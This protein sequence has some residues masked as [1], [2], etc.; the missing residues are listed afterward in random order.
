MRE[1]QVSLIGKPKQ[2]VRNFGS[3]CIYDLANKI[4]SEKAAKPARLNKARID[5]LSDIFASI[6]MAAILGGVHATFGLCG[7]R[8]SRFPPRFVSIADRR[9]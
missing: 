2:S 3:T 1:S 8:V 9:Y 6:S 5:A 4:V 7:D